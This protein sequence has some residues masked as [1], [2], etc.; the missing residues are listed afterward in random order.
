[1]RTLVSITRNQSGKGYR[2]MRVSVI[3]RRGLLAAVTATVF[4]A[5][6]ARDAAAQD[7][8]PIRIGFI[9]D[10]T[11]PFAGGGSEPA[12]VGT[13]LMVDRINAAG[14]VKGHKIEAIYADARSKVDVAITEAERLSGQEKADLIM[15]IYSS[16]QCVP[17][18]QKMD[19]AKVFMWAN[20]C[21]SSAVFKDKN[22][23]YVFRPTAHSDQFGQVSVDMIAHYAKE[24]LGQDAE[25]L[26]VAI[27]HEDGPYGVGVASANEAQAKKHGMEIVLHEGYSATSPDLSSLVTKLKRARADVI[28]HTGYNPD[29]TLFMRQARELGL[30]WKALV[31]HGAGHSQF[32]KLESTFGGDADLL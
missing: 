24:K 29:I 19:A 4:I 8:E 7:K 14:G 10:Y 17:L 9:H 27:I 28:F 21:I 20:I 30:R 6:A 22:L 16:A 11:G 13:K 1:M 2:K 5:P 23:T 31:G 12:A 15:G 32:D 26:K 3:L 18:A 25:D